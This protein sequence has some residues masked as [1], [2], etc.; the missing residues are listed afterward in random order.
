MTWVNPFTGRE[1]HG[2]VHLLR[3]QHAAR[4]AQAEV[5][6]EEPEAIRF[7]VKAQTES[8][9]RPVRILAGFPDQ[10]RAETYRQLIRR[11]I[12]LTGDCNMRF[13]GAWVEKAPRH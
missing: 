1:E 10:E 3:E 7:F 13:V 9:T 5:V 12:P 6:A 4:K 11:T 8:R 2:Y